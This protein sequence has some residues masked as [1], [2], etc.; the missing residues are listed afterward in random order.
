MDI[1]E[2]NTKYDSN[3][4]KFNQESEYYNIYN[5]TD[6]H[7]DYE[8]YP[9]PIFEFDCKNLLKI[10][11]EDREFRYHDAEFYDE[12]RNYCQFIHL[13]TLVYY[14]KLYGVYKKIKDYQYQSIDLILKAISCEPKHKIPWKYVSYEIVGEISGTT[15]RYHDFNG[16]YKPEQKCSYILGEKYIKYLNSF[17][18]DFSEH[19]KNCYDTPFSPELTLL[20]K[21]KKGFNLIYNIYKNKDM[22]FYLAMYL[23]FEYMFKINPKNI[24]IWKEYYKYTII[25]NNATYKNLMCCGEI[26]NRKKLEIMRKVC[27][28]SNLDLEEFHCGEEND[29]LIDFL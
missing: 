21:D 4:L 8:C 23:F 7:S 19:V 5:G 28:E 20:L 10:C 14:L 12:Y 17:P 2:I 18:L 11:M 26:N 16:C 15:S 13:Q 29:D 6:S 22:T 24:F 9:D 25:F 27:E 1:E 3:L